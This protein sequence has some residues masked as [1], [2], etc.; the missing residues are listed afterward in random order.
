MPNDVAS[1]TRGRSSTASASPPRGEMLEKPRSDAAIAV[2]EDA[3]QRWNRQCF[4][5]ASSPVAPV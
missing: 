3:M 4:N 5:G 1:T 2:V